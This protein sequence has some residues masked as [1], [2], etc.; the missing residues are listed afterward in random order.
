MWTT[1]SAPVARISSL[2][3]RSQAQLVNF[4]TLGDADEVY[5]NLDEHS[6]FV[7]DNFSWKSGLDP[8][9]QKRRLAKFLEALSPEA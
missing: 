3:I 5:T 7:L 9:G 4:L 8:A 6:Q 1:N 2:L